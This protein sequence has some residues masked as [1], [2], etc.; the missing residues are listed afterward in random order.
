M[1]T[2]ERKVALFKA[3]KNIVNSK[4]KKDSLRAQRMQS[5]VK[6][7][8][9]DYMSLEELADVMDEESMYMVLSQFSR[10]D[11]AQMKSNWFETGETTPDNSVELQALYNLLV[12]K[13][14]T[15]GKLDLS[16]SDVEY[17]SEA[18]DIHEES[19]PSIDFSDRYGAL[20]NQDLKQIVERFCMQEDVL[21][22][23]NVYGF[24]IERFWYLVLFVK[25][26]VEVKCNNAFAVTES[27][28][29]T[30][31][32]FKES[33][34]AL[35]KHHKS[36]K[37]DVA[38][39]LL[40]NEVLSFENPIL[41]TVNEHS[42]TVFKSSNDEA[43]HLIAHACDHL[44]KEHDVKRMESKRPIDI[45]WTRRVT[46]FYVLMKR[47]LDDKQVLIKS[48]G[49][50]QDRN[51]LVARLLCVIGWIPDD[52]KE[53]YSNTYDKNYKANRKFYNLIKNYKDCLSDGVQ[54][55]GESYQGVN[56]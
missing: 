31:C 22:T 24:D 55:F 20:Y 30:I 45:S 11:L 27:V 46:M 41:F 39:E 18:F 44:L 13:S 33:I 50:S 12:V 25:D 10:T 35:K 2:H 17:I 21:H 52:K 9:E 54:Y 43:L 40:E 5:F 28:Y 34:D 8:K 36:A 3:M 49:Y 4:H 6:I 38:D 7:L 32:Q 19:I 14:N 15:L 48:T 56:I 1:L 37:V 29:D 23:I 26:V 16:I 51:L 42:D 47:F 53:V